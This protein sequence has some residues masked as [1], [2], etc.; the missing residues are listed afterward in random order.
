MSACRVGQFVLTTTTDKSS[1][2]LGETAIVDLTVH[3]TSSEAC[4]D[5]GVQIGGCYGTTAS[6]SA[7]GDVWDSM[8]GPDGLPESCPSDA[9]TSPTTVPGNFSLTAQLSWAQDVYTQP[10]TNGQPNPDRPQ[11]QLPSGRYRITGSWTFFLSA[12]PVTIDIDPS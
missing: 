10:V 7:G 9:L 11:T 12:P 6:N 8:A 4:L 5:A 2:S 3:D 1:Y